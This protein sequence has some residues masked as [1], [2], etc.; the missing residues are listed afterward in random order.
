MYELLIANKNYSSWSLRPWVLMRAMDIPFT[1]RQIPFPGGDSWPTYKPISPNGRVPCLIDGGRPVWDSL[2]IVE[3]LAERH[4][5]VWSEDAQARAW[6]RCAAAEMHSSFQALRDI[7]TMN[8]GIRV[9]LKDRPAAL[10]RDIARIGELWSEGLSRFGGP[11][12]AG[13]SFTGVDAFYAPVAF[14]ARTYGLTFGAQADAWVERM[15]AHP[16][17]RDWY[18]AA[19]AESWREEG[20]E[21][22]ARAAGE[23]IEDLRTQL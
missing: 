11:W 4:P 18:E 16:A 7:C 15:L 20:H 2:A 14:R 21:A 8:C 12:L 6:S 9:R 19:L 1:E 5:G 3:Y 17:M 23:W 10:E 22:E 13:P